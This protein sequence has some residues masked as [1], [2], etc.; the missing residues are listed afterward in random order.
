[1]VTSDCISYPPLLLTVSHITT[2][3]IKPCVCKKKKQPWIISLPILRMNWETGVPKVLF[4][5][6]PGWW[7]TAKAERPR[8]AEQPA[9]RHFA[10][11]VLHGGNKQLSSL[12]H[13]QVQFL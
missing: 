2:F 12:G 1:M 6:C 3:L 4:H 5:R 8:E 13:G 10:L 11:D 9:L 7:D